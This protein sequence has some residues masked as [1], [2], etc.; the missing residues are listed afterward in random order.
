MSSASGLHSYFSLMASDDIV[1]GGV[2][3]SGERGVTGIEDGGNGFSPCEGE[4]LEDDFKADAFGIFGTVDEFSFEGDAGSEVVSDEDFDL[5]GVPSGFE[6]R[7]YFANSGAAGKVVPCERERMNGGDKLAFVVRIFFLGDEGCDVANGEEEGLGLG[8]VRS[9]DEDE[10]KGNTVFGGAW[11]LCEGDTVIGFIVIEGFVL[12]GLDEAFAFFIDFRV[13]GGLIFLARQAAAV[14]DFAPV[15]G[16]LDEG[17]QGRA[18]SGQ[19][20]VRGSC[21]VDGGF[22]LGDDVEGC[23]VGG[24]AGV[25]GERG[26]GGVF[27]GGELIDA[28][29]RVE[30]E[31]SG[32]VG[33]LDGSLIGGFGVRF[34]VGGG[35]AVDGYSVDFAA[36]EFCEGETAFGGTKSDD[37]FC[38]VGGDTA[39]AVSGV[40]VGGGDAFN[41]FRGFGTGEDEGGGDEVVFCHDEGGSESSCCVVR[42]CHVGGLPPTKVGGHYQRQRMDE[43]VMYKEGGLNVLSYS[44]GGFDVDL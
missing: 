1:V 31:A 20:G 15:L 36:K 25:G 28:S 18:Q 39:N 44:C 40:G 4:L 2:F 8:E 38:A 22:V 11:E 24:Q 42:V 9:L 43:H 12:G 21:E 19:E 30:G 41:R 37:D 32:F 5:E 29:A 17:F 7:D 13:D 23:E 27:F 34:F 3:L 35:A 33:F 26:Q 14:G 6:V 16:S 10:G